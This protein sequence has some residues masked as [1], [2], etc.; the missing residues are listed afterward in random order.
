MQLIVTPDATTAAAGAA[1][2]L[3]QQIERCIRERG[4]CT[5]AL[6]GGSTPTHMFEVLATLPVS[7]AQ[8]HVFQ[9]DE[10][11]VASRSTHRNL[12]GLADVFS[13][14]PALNL[15]AMPVEDPDLDAAARD[16]ESAL[17]EYCGDLAVLDLV[18]LGLG[19]DGHTASLLPGDALLAVRDRDVAI[20]VEYQGFRR[21][22]L[23]VP[24]L[25]RARQVLWLV[26]GGDKATALRELLHPSV[27][28]S[29]ASPAER[30]RL[31][32][33]V[34]FADEDAARVEISRPTP[35]A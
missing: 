26:T 8:L 35:N 14:L 25:R 9:V 4:R 34:V 7:W 3:A 5:L 27:E 29:K 21:M 28:R 22:T 1:D 23:T 18:H 24:I 12:H 31:S 15:H 32:N 20:T 11:V 13:Q 33:A 2:W 16:Y 17:R 30:L 6:S 10:R 19:A